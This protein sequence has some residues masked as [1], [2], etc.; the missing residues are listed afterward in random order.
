MDP[1]IGGPPENVGMITYELPYL[2]YW[3]NPSTAYG[4]G[5]GFVLLLVLVLSTTIVSRNAAFFPCVAACFS[6]FV[7]LVLRGAMVTAGERTISMYQLSIV[8]DAL[9]GHIVFLQ[10]YLILSCWAMYVCVMEKVAK[11]IKLWGAFFLAAST[12]MTSVGVSLVF[13]DSPIVRVPVLLLVTWTVFKMILYV[14]PLNSQL[15]VSEVYYYCFGPFIVSLIV[16]FWVINNAPKSFLFSVLFKQEAIQL[17]QNHVGIL[18]HKS[19]AYPELSHSHDINSALVNQY[20]SNT[21][22]STN[23]SI[24]NKNSYKL[25]RKTRNYHQKGSEPKK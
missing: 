11:W 24:E 25:P 10:L 1:S 2:Q 13:K 8:L 16:F 23:F 18:Q 19:I 14:K 22:S 12:L 17:E 20:P 21:N 9:S 3:P 6:A 5:S 7:S 4:V 15:N